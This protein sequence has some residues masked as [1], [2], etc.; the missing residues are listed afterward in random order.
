MRVSRWIAAGCVA[1]FVSGC[2]SAGP[3]PADIAAQAESIPDTYPELTD[4]PRISDANTDSAYWAQVQAELLAAGQTVRANPRSQPV[5]AADD[6]ALFLEEARRDI[7]E[8]R[9]SHEPN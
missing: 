6:P 4:V 1:L 2:A 3:L 8:A 9:Q 5:T 7:E